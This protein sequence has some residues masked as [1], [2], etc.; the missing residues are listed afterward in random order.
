MLVHGKDICANLYN[1]KVDVVTNDDGNC[2]TPTK[3]YLKQIPL[4]IAGS[5]ITVLALERNVFAKNSTLVTGQTLQSSGNDAHAN[6]KKAISHALTLIKGD[7]SP[8]ESGNNRPDLEKQVLD[9]IYNKLK[10]KYSI[11][12]PG[13]EPAEEE[14]AD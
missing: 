6:V 10:G 11:W 7:G 12:G 4:L 2:L 13:E 8:K 5:D 9:W 3:L 14:A 1:K